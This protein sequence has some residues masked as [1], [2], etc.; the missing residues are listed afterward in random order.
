LAFIKSVGQSLRVLV[1]ASRQMT[2][3]RLPVQIVSLEALAQGARSFFEAVEQEL[4]VFAESLR[5]WSSV[6]TLSQSLSIFTKTVRQWLVSAVPS[7]TLRGSTRAL[8]QLSATRLPSQSISMKAIA[9]AISG[10]QVFVDSVFQGL[11]VSARI[12]QDLTK[13]V[14]PPPPPPTFPPIFNNYVRSVAQRLSMHIRTSGVQALFRTVEETIISTVRLLTEF[15]A[16]PPLIDPPLF[17]RRFVSAVLELLGKSTISVEEAFISPLRRGDAQ[18]TVIGLLLGIVLTI[19]Y[20]F[21]IRWREKGSPNFPLGRDEPPEEPPMIPSIPQPV[22]M[23]KG[24]G[25]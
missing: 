17:Y 3:V 25:G 11:S 23:G 12:V 21:L 2:A 7:E 14:H 24:E 1:Q 19:I 8:K 6:R 20:R 9:Q 4:G 15:T 10:F 5:Q 16:V 13:F 22:L 18:R